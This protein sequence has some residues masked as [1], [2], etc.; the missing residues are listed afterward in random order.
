LEAG[1][2]RKEKRGTEKYGTPPGKTKKM[3]RE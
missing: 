3:L 1:E 2:G